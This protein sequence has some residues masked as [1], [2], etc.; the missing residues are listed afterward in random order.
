MVRYETVQVIVDD[1][2]IA[3]RD[4]WKIVHPV[5]WKANIYD[6]PDEYERSLRPFSQS[7]RFVFAILWYQTEV[8]NG[9]H[10]QFYDNST[11]IVW[12]DALDAFRKLDLLEFA[13]IVEQSASRLGG[14]PSLDRLERSKQMLT[15]YPEFRDLDDLF[16]DEEKVVDI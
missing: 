6:G 1:A 14:S 13:K 4:I 8:N 15:F 2:V 11:G 5:W 10:Q 16:Y 3:D 7:Q 12:A 9:G